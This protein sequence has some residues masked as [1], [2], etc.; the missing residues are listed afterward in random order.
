MIF[1]LQTLFHRPKTI[2]LDFP[3]ELCLNRGEI[4]LSIIAQSFSQI[5][6]FALEK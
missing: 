2:L 3:N 5:E 4:Q 6:T 1:D